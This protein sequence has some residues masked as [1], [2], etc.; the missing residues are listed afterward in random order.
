MKKIVLVT[1][2]KRLIELVTFALC[3]KVNMDIQLLSVTRYGYALQDIKDFAPDLVVID[4][5]D[6]VKPESVKLSFL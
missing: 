4:A 5:T 2:N 6:Y 3:E 1:S